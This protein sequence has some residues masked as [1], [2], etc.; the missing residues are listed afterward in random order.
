MKQDEVELADVNLHRQYS[1]RVVGVRQF[2]DIDLAQ[3]PDVRIAQ[4]AIM[5]KQSKKKMSI[6]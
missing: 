6:Y 2:Y 1:G 4:H 3:Q 5:C